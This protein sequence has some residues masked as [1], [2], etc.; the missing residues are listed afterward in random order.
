MVSRGRGK[1][2][3]ELLHA[4]SCSHTGLGCLGGP[5]HNDVSVVDDSV[6]CTWKLGRV[7]SCDV[8]GLLQ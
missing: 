2:S 8:G 5:W 3:G 4:W 1:G 6:L 7:I